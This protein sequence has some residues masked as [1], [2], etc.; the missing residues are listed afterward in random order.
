MSI[1]ERE[2]MYRRGM[3]KCWMRLCP[4]LMAERAGSSSWLGA[5]GREVS[6]LEEMLREVRLRR[7]YI[8]EGRDW[9]LF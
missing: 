4:R 5:S 8:S 7:E 1:S 2:D 9:S 6:W 3:G